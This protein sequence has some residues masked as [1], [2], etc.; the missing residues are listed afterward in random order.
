MR[1]DDVCLLEFPGE[2]D[3]GTGAG[4]CSVTALHGLELLF[5]RRN[6]EITSLCGDLRCMR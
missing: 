3:F 1:L 5:R 4:F 6:Y 2:T